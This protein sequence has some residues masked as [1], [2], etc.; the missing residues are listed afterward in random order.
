[1]SVQP[2]ERKSL[3]LSDQ[4]KVM[5]V[6]LIIFGFAIAGHFFPP[7]DYKVDAKEIE[8]IEIWYRA[9]YFMGEN[10]KHY[11][12]ERK[13]KNFYTDTEVVVDSTLINNLAE[14]FTGLYESSEFETDLRA[15]DFYPQFTVVITYP[16]GTIVL[17]SQSNYHCFIPWNVEYTDEPVQ[18]KKGIS[19]EDTKVEGDT[20]V[21][22]NGDI[23]TALL[24][25]LLELDDYW[26]GYERLAQWGCYSAEVPSKYSEKGFS[27]YFPGCTRVVSPEE[28]KGAPRVVWAQNVK[29]TIIGPPLYADEKVLVPVT[30]GILCFDALTGDKIW[31]TQ[32]ED[33]ILHT[34]G[35]IEEY[36]ILKN[37]RLFVTGFKG[38]FCLDSNTGKKIWEVAVHVDGPPLYW[39]NRL[40]LR[41]RPEDPYTTQNISIICLDTA[42]GVQIWEYTVEQTEKYNVCS[43]QNI[44]L[45]NGKIYFGTG[46]PSVYCIDAESGE[47]IWKFTDSHVYRRLIISNG[48]LL[49]IEGWGN[50]HIVCL[51]NE[52]GAKV[53]E[54]YGM[55]F[56]PPYD[57]RIK[58]TQH[59]GIIDVLLDTQ[60]GEPLWEGDIY[61]GI[62][63]DAYCNGILYIQKG[64]KELVALDIQ[65]AEAKELWSHTF[66]AGVTRV[67]AFEQGILVPVVIP[68]EEVWTTYIEALLFLDIDGT[69][70]WEH[71]YQDTMYDGLDAFIEENIL[72]VIKRKGFLEAFDVKTRKYL[73]KTGVRGNEITDVRILGDNLYIC[74]NDGMV[75]CL[76]LKSGE[77]LWVIDTGSGLCYGDGRFP[78]TFFEFYQ[79]ML[80]LFTEDGN[81]LVIMK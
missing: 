9:D 51:N 59:D 10:E 65:N 7:Q 71:K 25:I 44:L 55:I 37:G 50:A 52:T 34:R 3:I 77:P 61:S 54:T 8:R 13:N 38:V 67:H 81:I 6:F 53:W 28:E 42:T 62:F 33:Y 5:V 12:I 64:R 39:E 70:L 75:Y 18:V 24:R 23:P 49:I 32:V 43:N 69:L 14:S 11:T 63:K 79:E 22:Y 19:L 57:D 15:T 48:N 35:N 27:P 45:G 76:A 16:E 40:F 68:G 66:E 1:M 29:E 56:E 73:W 60:T 30:K 20:F 2:R 78:P 36:V 26:S 74:A 31:E 17:R 41:T 80:F 72:F 46:E 21:Q 4:M 47:V 58:V